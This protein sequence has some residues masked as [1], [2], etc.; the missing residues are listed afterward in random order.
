[1]ARLLVREPAAARVIVLLNGA[2]GIGKSTV[3]RAL[4]TRLPRSAIFDPELAGIALQRLPSWIPVDGRGTDDFQ[5]LPAWRR[6]TIAG[7]RATRALR[8]TVIVPMAFTNLAYLDQIRAGAAA[9]D[10]DVRHVCLVAPLAV[11][12]HRQSLRGGGHMH[13]WQVRRAAECCAVH[14]G[15]EFAEQIDA[16]RSG[17]DEIAR[18]IA[19][20]L[21]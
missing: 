19:E 14:G 21:T 3:A 16:E 10:P 7:I 15:P 12:L 9:S 11:V 2:F 18:A 20:R 4:R 17:P 5:D 1:V 8:R 13:Q 6:A